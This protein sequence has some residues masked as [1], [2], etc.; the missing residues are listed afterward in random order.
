MGEASTAEIKEHI[1]KRSRHGTSMHV[2]GNVLSK[3]PQYFQFAGMIKI[4]SGHTNGSYSQS[5]TGRGRGMNRKG[6]T[7]P[8][9]GSYE[10][11]TWKC[12]EPFIEADAAKPTGSKSHPIHFMEKK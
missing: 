12:A 5:N 2:L 9:S 3:Y 4:V 11:K 8:T 7:K 10:M 1:N 6:M